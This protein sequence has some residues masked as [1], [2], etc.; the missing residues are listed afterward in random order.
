MDKMELISSVVRVVSYCRC[1][2]RWFSVLLYQI[3][4]SKIKEVLNRMELD[5][6]L[7]GISDCSRSSHGLISSC[8]GQISSDYEPI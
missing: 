6:F 5:S 8:T 1:R 2:G 7:V 4:P 3:S